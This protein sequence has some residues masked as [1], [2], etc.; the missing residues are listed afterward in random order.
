MKHEPM[1]IK[2][3]LTN[4]S[5]LPLIFLIFLSSPEIV[6]GQPSVKLGIDYLEENKLLVLAG[7]RVG[8]LTHPAGKM[9]K[10][11]AL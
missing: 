5:F 10:E 6:T 8:L 1:K 2:L 11:K 3:F 7:K 4:L 9:E